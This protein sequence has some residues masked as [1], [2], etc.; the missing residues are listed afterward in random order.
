MKKIVY[1]EYR[2][3]LKGK[4]YDILIPRIHLDEAWIEVGNR[5]TSDW[6]MILMDGNR[7]TLQVLYDTMVTLI[8][9]KDKIVYLPICQIPMLEG[10]MEN[11]I[12][13]DLVFYNH[14]IRFKRNRWKELKRMMKYRKPELYTVRYSEEELLSRCK[15]IWEKYKKGNP[16]YYKKSRDKEWYM[17]KTVFLE[18]SVELKCGEIPYA[19]EWLQE[20]FEKWRKGFTVRGMYILWERNFIILQEKC[21]EE[22]I[23]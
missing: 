5:I 7:T 17:P 21:T 14:Q 13:Y 16:Y 1:E 6:V 4:E 15:K 11:E 23:E 8:L 9:E 20:D 18:G 10:R 3:K 19:Y 12:N 22:G 2:M